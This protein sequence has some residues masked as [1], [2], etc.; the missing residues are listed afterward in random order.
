[1]LD[2]LSYLTAFRYV[3][4][5]SF[6]VCLFMLYS[7]ASTMPAIKPLILKGF[8]FGLTCACVC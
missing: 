4:I 3:R 2:A 8:R 1:M 6:R 7:T 5:L